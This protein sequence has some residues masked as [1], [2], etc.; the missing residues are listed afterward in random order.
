MDDW[1]EGR[2]ER[3]RPKLGTGAITIRKKPKVTPAAC[4]WAFKTPPFGGSASFEILAYFESALFQTSMFTCWA[5][6]S[7]SVASRISMLLMVSPC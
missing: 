7:S 5:A 3:F 6:K 2:P 4:P 1:S